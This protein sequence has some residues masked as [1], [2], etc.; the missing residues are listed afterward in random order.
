MYASSNTNVYRYK[1]KEDGQVEDTA[2]PE[3]IVSGL[4]D[5]GQ[6]NSKSIVLD[7]NRNIY[8]NIGAYSNSCQE[9]DRE[10]GSKE[11]IPVL[12]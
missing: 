4:I 8:V 10:N 6:H 7:N 12:F 1:L 2:K 11:W 5:R 9:H 3:L